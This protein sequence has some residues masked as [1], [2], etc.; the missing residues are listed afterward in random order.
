MKKLLV[1]VIVLLVIIIMVLTRPDKAAHKEA[2]MEAVKEF[3]ADEADSMG[4][5]DN[6]LT[7]LGKGIVNKTIEKALNMKLKMH[8][9]LIFNTTYVKL[10]G[11]EQM[12][13]VGLF[14]HVFTFDSEMLHEKL[15]QAADEKEMIKQNERELKE[16]EKEK[17]KREKELRKERRRQEKDSIKA[18]KKRKKE[19]ERLQREAEKEQRR[20]EREAEKERQRQE[21][22]ASQ[23]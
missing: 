19:E 9:Y 17:K 13:S 10:M 21:R 23:E 22:E 3:V 15:E 16:L 12:L 8:D 6:V 11:E 14:G 20:L 18:E 2:M 1:A 7:D 4:M 5:G